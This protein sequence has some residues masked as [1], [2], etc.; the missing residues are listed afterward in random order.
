M[1]NT[2]EREKTSELIRGT[3]EL[4]NN[5]RKPKRIYS[6]MEGGM[7]SKG[8]DKWLVENNIDH[9]MTRS[10]ANT[11]ERAIRTFKDLMTRRL[12]APGNENEK[13][14][15]T[16]VRLAVL[17]RYNQKMVNRTTGLTPYEAIETKNEAHVRTMLEINAI[18][19]VS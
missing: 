7:T 11:A 5:M 14:Y 19:K 1:G 15:D 6:D 12:E 9:V 16:R 4:I 10:H 13:W 2:F 17:M 8:W 18:T 3:Q